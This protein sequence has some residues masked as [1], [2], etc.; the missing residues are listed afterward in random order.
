VR[1]AVKMP[2]AATRPTVTPAIGPANTPAATAPPAATPIPG[3]RPEIQSWYNPTAQEL[4]QRSRQTRNA[5]LLSSTGASGPPF[6]PNT[7]PA[8]R[9]T[10]S[11]MGV[12][13]SADAVVF[14]G[15]RVSPVVTYGA[16]AVAQGAA[17][18][19][20]AGT[21]ERPITIHPT[22]YPQPPGTTVIVI[23]A[24]TINVSGRDYRETR[25]AITAVIDA[26]RGSNEM[27]PEVR[28]QLTS[29]M[30]A[31]VGILPAPKVDRN[32]VDLLLVRPLRYVAEKC[33]S[34]AV[35]EL[36]KAALKALAKLVGLD[37]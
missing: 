29:E 27:P 18:A 32:L 12:P 26:V 28:N 19:D 23:N 20:A 33:A 4:P 36:A 31:G 7:D 30:S 2:Q 9:T 37:L 5:A 16:E 3:L 15:N 11:R 21:V 1:V 8:A 35:A 13:S 14:G 17:S 6:P 34:V 10:L 22:I 25:K 24:L